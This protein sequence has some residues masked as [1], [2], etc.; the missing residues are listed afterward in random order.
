MGVRVRNSRLTPAAILAQDAAFVYAAETLFL[1]EPLSVWYVGTESL[2]DVLPELDPAALSPD[3]P[4]LVATLVNVLESAT[5][6]W[7]LDEDVATARLT[8]TL[9]DDPLVDLEEIAAAQSQT[10]AL[11]LSGRYD[12]VP[13]TTSADGFYQLGSPNAP[14]V[15]E[16]FS[17]YACPPCANFHA[18]NFD[19][20][21]DYARTG[22]VVVR[23]IPMLT[24]DEIVA[25]ARARGAY[26]AG[27]QGRYW[28]FH[29]LM[30]EDELQGNDDDVVDQ[31]FA[32]AQALAL[33]EA[34][35]NS[36]FSTLDQ[37]V[38]YTA[39]ASLYA[40]TQGVSSTPTI[41][42]NGMRIN[43][44]DF[45]IEIDRALSQMGTSTSTPEA[46][47]PDQGP[48]A[49]TATAIS[50]TN[51]AIVT[52]TAD[53]VAPT[54]APTATAPPPTATAPPPETTEEADGS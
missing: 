28:T 53:A 9:Q 52:A 45:A 43:T 8:L 46:A 34:V 26:C 22:D 33:D 25:S 7:A 10:F 54:M 6:T 19:T 20:L 36:C 29:D 13:Q 48:V 42:I 27:Q 50:E 24:G 18:D 17:S 49:L 11:E 30:F 47:T 5:I 12:D 21:I 38:S 51:T 41:F 4:Q 15:V 40:Q 14:V 23:F 31:I 1:D 32:D 3:V 16:L 39:D 2:V 44:F 35:F 37:S